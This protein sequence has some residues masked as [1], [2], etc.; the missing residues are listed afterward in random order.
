MLSKSSHS[1]GTEGGFPTMDIDFFFFFLI[2][3]PCIVNFLVMYCL[4]YC[5]ICLIFVT[6][7]IIQSWY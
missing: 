4:L 5:G 7:E 6:E 1:S 3:G 2:L